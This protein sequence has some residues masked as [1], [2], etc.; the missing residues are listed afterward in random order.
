MASRKETKKVRLELRKNQQVRT[1]RNNLT[2]DFEGGEPLKED[3]HSSGERLSGKGELTRKRTVISEA[4]AATA[5]ASEARLAADVEFLSGRV[6]EAHGLNCRVEGP[7]RR[8]YTCAT[9]RLLRSLQSE[10]RHVVVT[11][12]RVR[13]R[14]VNDLEGMIEK[15]EPRRGVLSRTSRGR[16]HMLVSN[17]DQLLIVVSAAE[18]T[19][20]PNL[21]DRFLISAE[22]GGI[23]AAIVINKVDLVDLAALQPLVGVYRQMG[24]PVHLVSAET[25]LNVPILQKLFADKITVVAGQS[26]V[27]K[28]SILNVIEDGLSLR[29]GRVAEENLKGRHTTTAAQLIP[30]S[31]GGYMVDTPGIRQ[32]EMW[33][34]TPQEVQNYFRDIRPWINLCKFPNCTHTHEADCAV[35]DAVAD[36][37]L[38][39]RRYESYLHLIEVAD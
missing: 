19:L 16:Q 18:P 35:K 11:G 1:R 39:A 32:F 4:D 5:P 7:N 3:D 6:L 23:P 36:N 8:L 21:I 13:F 38:D 27:G 15:I 20:K 30:L 12:D 26:G 34:L 31:M 14:L 10:Q 22:Q 29:V 17:V 33:D 24:Y 2:R 9:R 37:Y 28:S 25:G